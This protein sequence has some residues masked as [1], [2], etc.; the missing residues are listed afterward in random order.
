MS[1]LFRTKT[2]WTALATGVSGILAAAGV[3]PPVLEAVAWGFGTL[4]AIC[5]RL[6]VLKSGAW[7]N[8]A[9]RSRIPPSTQP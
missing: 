3:A 4:T 2:F 7:V 8:P 6:G 9:L 5:M 1:H